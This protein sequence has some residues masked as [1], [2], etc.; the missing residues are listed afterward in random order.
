MRGYEHITTVNNV[1]EDLDVKDM[2]SLLVFNKS[3]AIKSRDHL[4]QLLFEYP[5]SIA[6]SAL[7]LED[8]ERLR[9]RIAEIVDEHRVELDL[10]IPHRDGKDLSII[11]NAGDVMIRED[12][13]EGPSTSS[14]RLFH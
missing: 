3:D 11:Y 4:D 9:D 8:M 10:F 12:E 14:T 5:G 13:P 1:L 2:P 7:N 6:I